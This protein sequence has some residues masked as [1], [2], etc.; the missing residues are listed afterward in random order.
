MSQRALR[1]AA[2]AASVTAAQQCTALREM[3]AAAGN[4]AALLPWPEQLRA[5]LAEADAAVKALLAV[6]QQPE[7]LAALEVRARL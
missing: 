3:A 2:R 1:R 5:R 7:G 6:C 4:A